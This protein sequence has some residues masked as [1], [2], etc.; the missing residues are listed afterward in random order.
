MSGDGNSGDGV[1]TAGPVKIKTWRQ[2]IGNP[3]KKTDGLLAWIKFQKNKW[4]FQ[5][6][7]KMSGDGNSGDGV[8]T[9]GPV[10]LGDKVVKIKVVE[11]N[12]A[13]MNVA[14]KQAIAKEAF[15][16]HIEIVEENESNVYVCK[17]DG[18]TFHP[19]IHESKALKHAILHSKGTK[20]KIRPK[21]I[22]KCIQ[23]E[24][25]CGK[26]VDL[27]R[28][29]KSIHA[30]DEKPLCSYCAKHFSSQDSLRRH[31]ST[32]HLKFTNQAAVS[33][34]MCVKTFRDQ[35]CLKRHIQNNH[36]EKK[37]ECDLCSKSFALKSILDKHV[38]CV[39]E[40]NVDNSVLKFECHRCN[41]RVACKSKL[42]KHMIK[43]QKDEKGLL[44]C[45][46]CGDE[47]SSKSNLKRHMTVIH[48]EKKMLKCK[49]CDKCFRDNYHKTR[50]EVTAHVEGGKAK[51]K[52]FVFAQPTVIDTDISSDDL[53]VQS[54]EI[55]FYF[56]QVESA[57][58]ESM[59]LC[60]I[61]N[62]IFTKPCYLK[63][64]YI[65]V[66]SNKSNHC[67]KCEKDFT[68]KFQYLKH[69]PCFV[70]CSFCDI[71]FSRILHLNNHMKLH[72]K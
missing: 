35:T 44:I 38:R 28:H 67:D 12:K 7:L 48:E 1:K 9:A 52:P 60:K 18:C 54:D 3:P 61:C 62:A 39:H 20:T 26:K 25:T 29:W 19:T 6:K 66:H 24:F 63:E 21:K 31:I 36:T 2:V 30:Q 51:M 64:H 72:S 37:F 22:I 43:H 33:C 11:K 40:V 46:I 71:T 13:K 17:T 56:S 70:K 32:I 34:S 53:Y 65:N 16:K 27:N 42:D 59:K 69:R 15:K 41:K 5:A 8:K 57:V 23:C 47:F 49:W 10:K 45:D 55:N 50:H 4:Q 68:T 14:E 58:V